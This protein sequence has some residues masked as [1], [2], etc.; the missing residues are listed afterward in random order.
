MFRS[1]ALWG[2]A[3]FWGFKDVG[4]YQNYGPVLGP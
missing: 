2:L 1:L 4:G 3:G